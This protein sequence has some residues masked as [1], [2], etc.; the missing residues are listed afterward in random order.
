MENY[1][2]MIFVLCG[3]C[4]TSKW[5]FSWLGLQEL[6]W[7]PST[8]DQP[9]I[10]LL[11]IN[12]WNIQ[13]IFTSYRWDKCHEKKMANVYERPGNA[14]NGKDKQWQ[15]QVPNEKEVKMKW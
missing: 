5:V 11:G 8:L 7:R 15:N 12:N 14:S 6:E 10:I 2:I 13:F 3:I 4:D 9:E 1:P